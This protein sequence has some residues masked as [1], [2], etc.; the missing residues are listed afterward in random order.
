[1]TPDHIAATTTYVV[2]REENLWNVSELRRILLS[3]LVSLKPHFCI[4]E[5]SGRL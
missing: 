3:N 1:M 5:F 4:F 2:C